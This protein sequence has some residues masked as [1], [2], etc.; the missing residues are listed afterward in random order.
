VQRR[1]FQRTGR[2]GP[3]PVLLDGITAAAT[4]GFTLVMLAVGGLGTPSPANRV[5]DATGVLLALLSTAPLALRRRWPGGVY[6]VTAA[7]SLLLLSLNYPLDV[8]WGPLIAVYLLA[9]AVGGDTPPRRRRLAVAA[10]AAFVP[11]TAVVLSL[12]GQPIWPVLPG[13]TVWSAMFAFMWIAGDR[14]RLRRERIAELEERALRRE[15]EAESQRRLAA[16]QERTRIAR[17]L[18]DSAG[19]AINVILVQ[20]GAARLL[21]ERDPAASARAIG[22]IEEVA[23]GTIGEIDRLGRA[24]R[25]DE[26]LQAPAPAD[27]AALEELV[28]QHRT[29][30]LRISTAFRGPRRSLPIGVGWAAYRILQEALTNAARHG[31]GTAEVAMSYGPDAVEITVCNPMGGP[32]RERG[33]G[34]AGGLGIVGM[35]ERA[36]L[37]GGSLETESGRDTFRL[38]AWLPHADPPRVTP[39][40]AVPPHA[41]PPRAVPPHAEP[42]RAVPPHAEPPNG[43]RAQ[44]ALRRPAATS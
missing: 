32:V 27:S 7:A 40:R 1:G 14:S 23:A 19:H 36:A 18:H 24:L 31:R 38:H 34:T 21:H 26:G 37:L 25:E 33:G 41:E 10:V 8:P 42:P 5:L 17:E 30:G 44:V 35:R 12:V 9:D 20:A 13:Y 11:V 28:D 4:T 39:P 2:G 15:R 22:V 3:R 29:G 6:A 43:E 16:A